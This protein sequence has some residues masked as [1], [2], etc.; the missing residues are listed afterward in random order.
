MW[1]IERVDETGSTNDDITPRLGAAE[2]GLVLVTDLQTAG[3]GRRAGRSWVAP[4]GSG[5]LF[6]AALPRPIAPHALWCVTFWA[7]LAIRDAVRRTCGVAPSLIWP[8]DLLIEGRKV[9]GILCVSRIEGERAWIAVGSGLN[10][11]RPRDGGALAEISPPPAF[12]SDLDPGADRG[13]LLD[14]ILGAYAARLAELDDPHGVA[15]RWERE[16]GLDG[17]PYQVVPDGETAP[18]SVIARRISYPGSL[19]VEQDGVER[20]VTLAD[21]RLLR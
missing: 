15:R 4:R 9:C 11:H 21:V 17:T 6:T 1:R 5:L 16:A 2:A 10:V 8:N 18:R 3:R 19:V 20:T 14:A 13:R 7:S 12:L